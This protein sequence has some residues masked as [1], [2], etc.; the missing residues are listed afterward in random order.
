MSFSFQAVCFTISDAGIQQITKPFESS[1][2]AFAGQGRNL[3]KFNVVICAHNLEVSRQIE[4]QGLWHFLHLNGA[5]R[6]SNFLD[7]FHVVFGNG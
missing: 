6:Q 7:R 5:D 3:I 1:L 2:S 4:H